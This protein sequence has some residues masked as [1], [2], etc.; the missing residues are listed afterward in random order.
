MTAQR[1]QMPAVKIAPSILAA[2][3]S[4]LG[5][6]AEEATRAGADYIHVD[7]MDGHFV[8]NITMGAVVVEGLRAS[9][10]LP[11]NV[12]LMIDDPDR[13][14]PDFV[15]AG[16]DHIIIHSESSPH[17]HRVI[18]QVKEAGLQV[19][20]AVNPS[21]PL[22]AVEELLSYVDI[23]LVSTV[24]PGFAGQKL[25]PEALAKVSRLRSLLN[26]NGH[27]AEIQVD[28][29]INAET[30]PAAVR[31]GAT[32]LVAGT[33]VFNKKESVEAGMKRLRESIKGV[34][35]P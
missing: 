23:A 9:T 29:G 14:I 33:A 35:G 24:N 22:A 10:Q 11:L 18:H 4:R 20:I 3:F 21:T 28:G 27:K 26:R 8:P 16:A 7:V 31:A 6:Q 19:G 13:F 34:N 25:I 5:E 32:I 2:D 17:L 15:K 30:A 1:G 12:H